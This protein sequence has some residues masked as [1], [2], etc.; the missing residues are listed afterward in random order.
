MILGRRGGGSGLGRPGRP[1]LVT[2]G[3]PSRATGDH[4]DLGLLRPPPRPL[5]RLWRRVRN[6]DGNF[7][8][9]SPWPLRSRRR[10]RVQ[11][12]LSWPPPRTLYHWRG[13]RVD[14]LSWPPPRTL[15]DWRLILRHFLSRPPHGPL[16][17]H[18][19]RGFIE[20]LW[21]S[22]RPQRLL[23]SAVAAICGRLGLRGGNLHPNPEVCL[24]WPALAL[25]RAAGLDLLELFA[26]PRR[27]CRS[28]RR[29]LRGSPIRFP[30]LGDRLL[31]GRRK[32]FL[33]DISGKRIDFPDRFCETS[34]RR[35]FPWP[36]VE[37]AC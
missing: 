31:A 13:V 25:R 15:Y 24:S 21:G 26:H 6:D 12:Y 28:I 23:L 34:E 17:P 5:R 18:G 29:S 8:R 10:V 7:S 22:S 36:C 35:I 3:S 19:Q 4:L 33:A 27:H 11:R 1:W 30:S 2:G 14:D 16:G 20:L 9:S 32:T 37:N